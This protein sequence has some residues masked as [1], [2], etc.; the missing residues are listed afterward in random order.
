MDGVALAIGQIVFFSQSE[1]HWPHSYAR[2]RHHEVETR[3]VILRGRVV[4][5]RWQEFRAELADNNGF[6]KDGEVFVF[7][8]N[9]L[10]SN[11]EFTD[12]EQLGV[13]VQ[14]KTSNP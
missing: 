12:F 3:S 4:A 7:P 6:E 14:N 13:W 2:K 10:L 9:K 1:E 11:Q 8:M 5:V